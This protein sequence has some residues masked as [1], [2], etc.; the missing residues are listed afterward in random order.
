[1]IRKYGMNKRHLLWG[2]VFLLVAGCNSLPGL[3]VL[4][5][6]DTGAG[7]QTELLVESA[8]LVMADKS[9]VGD[10]SLMAAADRIEAAAGIADIIEIRRDETAD[11]FV[12]N[13]IIPP[14][15]ADI[16]S[17]ADIVQYLDTM[18]RVIEMTWQGTL[19]ESEGSD[20]L[21]V[22]ILF[23]V[24]VAT[25]NSGAQFAGQVFARTEIDREEA[26]A[27]LSNRPHSL[28]EFGDLIL[29]GTINYEQNPG[30]WYEGEPNHPMFMLSQPS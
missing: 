25:L 30:V 1:M 27:Y 19:H 9:G 7:A 13:L 2:I 22:T 8:D 18:R 12:V 15:P 17:N 20:T 4:T 11:S 3:R 21:R 6:E 16:S 14:P 10:P 29:D 28:S 26:L 24:Q 5:G 23:P